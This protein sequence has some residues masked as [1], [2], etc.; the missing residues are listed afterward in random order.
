M[1]SVILVTSDYE[2]LSQGKF[3]AIRSSNIF[4]YKQFPA[5]FKYA[6]TA[7]LREVKPTPLRFIRFYSSNSPDRIIIVVWVSRVNMQRA[8]RLNIVK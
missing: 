1:L 8:V 3:I 7:F 5:A 6:V 2:K 4:K